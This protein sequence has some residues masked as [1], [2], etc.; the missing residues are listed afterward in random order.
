MNEKQGVRPGNQLISLGILFALIAISFYVIFRNFSEIDPRTIGGILRGVQPGFLAL[1]LLCLFLYILTEGVSMRVLSGA[2]GHPYGAVKT[3][4]Y[5]AIDLYFSAITPS[6]TGGQPAVAYYMAQDGIPLTK[7]TTLL[8]ANLIQYTASLLFMGLIVLIIKPGLVLAGGKWILILFIIGVVLHV[9][10]LVAFALCMFRQKMIRRLAGAVLHLLCKL[11][12][13]KNE[14]E[15]LAA[16]DQQLL[17]YHECVVLVH[18][19]PG[20]LL[21]VFIGNILQRVAMFS[22]AYF[23]YRALGLSAHSYWEL[24]AV[25]IVIALAV[26]SLPLPG[27]VGAAE[28]AFLMLYTIIYSQEFLMPAMLLTRGVSHYLCFILCGIIT[29]VNHIITMKTQRKAREVC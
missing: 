27:A 28:A 4:V 21:S 1:A 18:K 5:S 10:M 22:I 15:R 3:I 16:F 23:V 11:R 13:V 24:M 20:L 6:A 25:Q 12:L 8:L 7:S 9:G 19:R 2:L 17:E 14:E 26:N 29:I